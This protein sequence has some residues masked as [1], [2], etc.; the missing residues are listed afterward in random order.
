MTTQGSQTRHTKKKQ[1][2]V[3]PVA[4]PSIDALG[5][6]ALENNVPGLSKVILKKLNM[7]NYEE[8]KSAMDGNP[9]GIDFGIRTYFDMFRKMED[10]FR[11]CAECKMLPDGLPPS[12]SLHRC[13]RCQNVYY[14]GPECQRAN[15][16]VHKR[17]CKKLR[18]VAL[19][20]LVEWLV[21]TGDIPFPSEPWTR[22]I[23]EVRG[24]EDWFSMQEQLEE[25]LDAILSGRYMT[26]LWANAGKPRPEPDALVE[27]VKRLVTDF[28]SRPLTVGLGLQAFGLNVSIRPATVHVV[29]AS[30]VETFNIRES[31]Y[32]ELGHMFP[33]HQGIEL[34][35]VGVDVASGP[36]LK[37]P[38]TTLV[39]QGKVQ[40]SSYKGLYH[41]FW[42][43]LVET[44]R[45]L[46]PDLVIG[47]HPGEG[48]FCP[49]CPPFPD[50]VAI[51]SVPLSHSVTIA[52]PITPNAFSPSIALLIT[53]N[54]FGPSL[55]SCP[56]S[57]CAGQFQKVSTP[58]SLEGTRRDAARTQRN[59]M[60][61][62]LVIG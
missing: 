4:G 20:R 34:V 53:T 25:K 45:A 23:Q 62:T 39:A 38:L 46:R 54:A 2:T 21:F 13:K 60:M 48:R 59:S 43:H 61:A 40:L 19:D 16:P 49:R 17:F 10:T 58:D 1:P 8:Y 47:F 44:G 29:G 28:Q 22:K 56:Y 51:R 3:Q 6:L 55:P 36:V 30:H 12:K 18:L 41:I 31:D 42:E 57:P 27:S 5:F 24:W 15:W 9:Q 14:C 37:P 50:P 7:K 11:F 35:M 33:G 26:L 32:D 52:L